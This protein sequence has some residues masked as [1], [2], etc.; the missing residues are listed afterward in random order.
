MV[1]LSSPTLTATSQTESETLS[2]FLV[3]EFRQLSVWVRP[4]RPQCHDEVPGE[5]RKY[6]LVLRPQLS[7]GP[8]PGGSGAMVGGD[9]AGK[10]AGASC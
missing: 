4:D 7:D 10:V 8:G 5:D 3:A 1:F 6:R 9:G 2:C